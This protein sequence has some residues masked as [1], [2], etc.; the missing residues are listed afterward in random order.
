MIKN[1]FHFFGTSHT[2]GGGFEF[3]NNPK[4][5]KCYG[6]F[7]HDNNEHSFSYPGCFERLLDSEYEVV[8]HAK[9]GYGNELMVRKVFEV[10]QNPNFDI[11]T[12]VLFL[13]F[14]DVGRKE[15][16]NN[17]LKDF[18]ILNYSFDDTKHFGLANKYWYDSKDTALYLHRKKDFYKE[19]IKLCLEVNTQIELV[20]R[21]ALMLISFLQNN[22]IN[23]YLTN[24][25]PIIKWELEPFLKI[26][27]HLIEYEFIHP[28]TGNKQ[29]SFNFVSLTEPHYHISKETS[30][31]YDDKHQGYFVN[32]V[33]A[34]TI[35]NR[36][37][38]DGY[39]VK[40]KEEVHPSEWDFIKKKIK[41][42]VNLL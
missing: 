38:D 19:Y 41:D 10:I 37:I 35:Y 16:W 32:K 22:N 14:S 26:K 40:L 20:Q 7:G 39:I 24:D 1:R 4:V 28:K 29:K 9:C 30:D 36:L 3:H 8:N 15:F 13:E 31:F 21:N 6:G 23:F 2:A 27:E 17:D 33:V 5:K 18:V 34:N 42:G 25:F 11:D 12:D